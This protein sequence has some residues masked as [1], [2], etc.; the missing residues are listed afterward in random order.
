[1]IPSPS[2]AARTGFRRGLG[3]A[4]AALLALPLLAGGAAAQPSATGSSPATG[5]SDVGLGPEGIGLGQV[6]SPVMPA[7]EGTIRAD[8]SVPG[9]HEVAATREVQSCDDLVYSLYN[10]LLTH[11]FDVKELPS[12]YDV[13]PT[14]GRSP[15][16]VEYYY[17]AGL[18]EGTME[19]APL[20]VLSPGIAT[21]PGMLDR[22]A[23]L[24][25]GH[26][27]VVALGYSFLNW[28]GYQVEL[29]AKGA[30]DQS[31]SPGS[32]LHGKIDFSRTILAGHSAGGGSVA[33]M[34]SLLDGAIN[35]YRDV[36]F[37]TAGFVDLM[38]G[39]ADGGATSPPPSV[40]AL[41]V[42]AEHESLVPWPA[43]RRSYDRHAGPAWWTVV[44][45]T[46]HGSYLDDPK[47]NAIGA[48]VLSFA[49][50]VTGNGSQS[51]TPNPAAVFE[52]DG[53]RLASDPE[54]KLTERKGL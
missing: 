44:A 17:P 26:G 5:S 42:V 51:G 30:V 24:Y 46:T 18:A 6:Q 47:Y 10:T 29:A 21:N 37:R 48:L 16:G 9:P 33:R 1:M 40:P 25:A 50:Y 14:G 52:G 35:G 13:V 12:C 3:A 31:L 23:R 22:Q 53:Y 19:S 54:L 32:P 27:Y 38:G 34:G 7:P 11:A 36:G 8:F 49:E 43:T 45:G 2:P 15:V 4:A 39:P 20:I 28:F 41:F